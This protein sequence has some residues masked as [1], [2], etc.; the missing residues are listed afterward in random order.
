MDYKDLTTLIVKVF[1]AFLVVHVLG[2]VPTFT[3]DAI[4]AFDGWFTIVQKIVLPL[5]FPLSAGL[6]M[7][8][9]P[10]TLTNKLIQGEKI[11]G[12][13]SYLPQLERIALSLLGFYLL[14]STVSDLCYHVSR[15]VLARGQSASRLASET[16]TDI[17]GAIIGSSIGLL[18]SL[19]FIFGARGLLRFVSK[20]RDRD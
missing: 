15:L 14:F 10:A 12:V 3:A 1:G 18:I 6:F 9:F 5:I 20:L 7:L 16:P 11:V 17:H 4:M 8:F 19:W 2:L 13:P